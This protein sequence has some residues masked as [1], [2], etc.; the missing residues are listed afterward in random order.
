MSEAR[1]ECLIPKGDPSLMTTP[2]GE[3]MLFGFRLRIE[4]PQACGVGQGKSFMLEGEGKRRF[5]HRHLELKKLCEGK[6]GVPGDCAQLGW[7]R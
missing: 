4:E 5:V 7:S 6:N 3:M 1:P 2:M